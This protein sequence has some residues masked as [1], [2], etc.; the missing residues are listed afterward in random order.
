ML[1]RIF[2]IPVALILMLLVLAYEPTSIQPQQIAATPVSNSQ[3]TQFTESAVSKGL[4]FEHTRRSHGLNSITDNYGNGVCVFDYDDDG[5]EDI[6][7]VAGQGTTRRYGRDH[8]WNREQSSRL[9]RNV[10]G[11]YFQ[12]QDLNLPQA[13]FGFGCGLGDLNHDGKTDI[14]V[15][16][17]GKLHLLL[18]TDNGFDY[19]A[20]ELAP[21][22]WPTGLVV[23]DFNQDGAND[24]L[25]ATLVKYHNDIKVGDQE[26]GYQ[27][28]TT[29]NTS[30]FDGQ[31]N[32]VLLGD[33]S[34][35][36]EFAVHQLNGQQRTLSWF[37][38]GVGEVLAV[39]AKGSNSVVQTLLGNLDSR[40]SV[41][42]S[43][44]FAATQV[45]VMSVAGQEHYLV[46]N[47]ASRGIQLLDSDSRM[48]Q[49]WV[50]G[51][52]NDVI[53]SRQSWAT[54]VQDFNNDGR[55]D[56]FLASGYDKPALNTPTRPQGS[57]NFLLWQNSAGG[58]TT[59]NSFSPNLARSSR[60]AAYG[61]FNN[62]GFVDL[63]VVN[64][65]HFAE[66][67]LNQGNDNHWVSFICQP[68]RLCQ[69]A[70]WQLKQQDSVISGDF[71]TR[72][73]PYLSHG[74][75]RL[76][77]GL[78]DNAAALNLSI[79]KQSFDNLQVDQIYR[80]DLATNT[81]QP[82]DS[83]YS[84]HQQITEVE[85]LFHRLVVSRDPVKLLSEVAVGHEAKIA[86]K[87]AP[88][89]LTFQTSLGRE[90]TTKDPRLTYT[91]AWLARHL[92][93]FNRDLINLIVNSENRLFVDRLNTELALMQDTDFCFLSDKLAY[94]FEEEEVLPETK[95]T[96][97]P[98]LLQ[99]ALVEKSSN[100]RKICAI[101]ALSYSEDT[102]IGASVMSLLDKPNA[103][104]QAS[105]VRAV[106]RLK[107]GRGLPKLERFCQKLEN[108]PLL[109]V[110]C[111]IAQRK[112][113]GSI[114]KSDTGNQS[115]F[116]A[117][118]QE[119]LLLKL[120]KDTQ[121][122]QLHGSYRASPIKDHRYLAYQ[123][124]MLTDDNPTLL[125]SQAAADVAEFV[126]RARQHYGQYTDE[127][128]QTAESIP[129]GS[130]QRLI[131]LMVQDL[132]AV[133]SKAL[134]RQCV[135]R[136]SLASICRQRFAVDLNLKQL[137][138]ASLAQ[139]TPLQY[140]YLL[141]TANVTQRRVIARQLWAKAE[142]DDLHYQG[143]YQAVKIID[144]DTLEQFLRYSFEQQLKVDAAWLQSIQLTAEAQTWF[145]LYLASVKG[146]L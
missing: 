64:N 42:A 144:G 119:Q 24:I 7:M 67:Y 27:A 125:H 93:V 68:K 31:N 134:V 73:Q 131:E 110:E 32:L 36:V 96:L 11:R 9:F 62:D 107:Y 53:D 112:I 135:L 58:F 14:V 71:M 20:Y 121:I 33:R 97:L 77:V 44:S 8:W 104:L 19:K 52:T 50:K 81:I 122:P 66:Y 136:Q 89:L 17:I 101:E 5:F 142:F 99:Q 141:A 34:K 23:T 109:S 118:H 74:S 90:L 123:A 10:Q 2:A 37:N 21:L 6:F 41:L 139:L 40:D 1:L 146:A 103:A 83:N 43:L 100:Y 3:P 47:H 48:N 35:A 60:G 18:R 86:H 132:D 13:V 124:V 128:V 106:G 80:L 55:Q 72:S 143:L 26:Y 129:Y 4:L 79:G 22:T 28:R 84:Q 38:A 111:Q 92:T 59:H 46:T 54:I 15:G 88:M 95:F 76:H 56:V 113:R 127:L 65:N 82:I 140:Y 114:V 75:E 108:K 30:D 105:V 70:S 85:D 39:N 117:L 91:I 25:V 102:T 94:W 78:S 145:S 130:N 120:P 138:E 116:F 29:I 16:D 49:A 51:L 12:S 57:Q 137:S 133:M 87:L 45:N 61:D 98:T 115:A 126:R 69:S 63:V